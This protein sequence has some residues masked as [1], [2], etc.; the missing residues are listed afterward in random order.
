MY[1]CKSNYVSARAH[2]YVLN[3]KWNTNR[4]YMFSKLLTPGAYAR[5]FITFTQSSLSHVVDTPVIWEGCIWVYF[6]MMFDDPPQ[7]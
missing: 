6:L 4:L 2:A 5:D 7:I 3:Q 1:K